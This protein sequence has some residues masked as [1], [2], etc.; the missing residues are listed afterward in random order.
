MRLLPL[1]PGETCGQTHSG[2][3]GEKNQSADR[4]FSWRGVP[5]EEN[6]QGADAVEVE[7]VAKPEEMGVQEP[8]GDQPAA[9]PEV[10]ETG[11][12]ASGP[13]PFDEEQHPGAKEQR[14]EAH[15][16]GVEEDVTE[17][18]HPQVDAGEIPESGRVAVGGHRHRKAL[19]VHHQDAQQRETAQDIE[20]HDAILRGDWSSRHHLTP[21]SRKRFFVEP[22]PSPRAISKDRRSRQAGEETAT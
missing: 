12:S 5:E 22:M 9:S 18:P 19:D 8:K 10:Q 20:A 13:G 3:D 15:E 7:D 4:Q 11:R 21:V 17:L 14:E 16:L 2:T 1:I 6:E